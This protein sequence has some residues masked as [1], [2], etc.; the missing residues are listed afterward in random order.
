MGVLV[1]TEKPSMKGVWIFVEQHDLVRNLAFG[2]KLLIS[3]KEYKNSVTQDLVKFNN[4][5]VCE[6]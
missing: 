4:N 6:H 3:G 5:L 2:L 1:Q